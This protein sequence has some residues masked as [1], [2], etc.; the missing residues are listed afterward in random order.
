MLTYVPES[1]HLTACYPAPVLRLIDLNLY[2]MNPRV[3]S[4]KFSMPRRSFFK[5]T[6]SQT[7][8][9]LHQKN[10]RNSSKGLTHTSVGG[11]NYGPPL[12]G[13]DLIDPA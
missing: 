10:R 7:A 9:Y 11:S 8:E 6:N 1:T 3:F 2:L 4:I 12:N 13:S 5:K